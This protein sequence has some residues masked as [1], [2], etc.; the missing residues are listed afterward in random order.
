M[1][2]PITVTADGYALR[3]PHV[4]VAL[5][6]SDAWHFVLRHWGI[7]A[8]LAIT[9]IVH[10]PTLRYFFDGDDFV[11]LGS[12]QYAGSKQYLID[13]LRM[14]DIVPNWRPLSALVYTAEWNAFGMNATA[15][16]SLNLAVHLSSL[17]V[18]YALVTR[19][20]KRP[21]VGAIAAVIFGVSGAHFDTVTY[22]TALP[23]ILGTSFMLASLLAIVSY[24]QDGER[25]AAAYCLSFALFALAF[26][27]NEGSFVY[28]P[29]VVAAYALFARRW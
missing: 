17:V 6:I 22:I 2:Y 13:T 8:A 21:A 29:V 5:A 12:I 4:D 3:R 25:S 7:F 1:K 9:F 16:R 27:T 28:A 14:Q 18:L 10:A 11:V 15:W 19:V 20:T 26:L 23:H 24:A